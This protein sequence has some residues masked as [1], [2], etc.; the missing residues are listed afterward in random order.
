MSHTY[1]YSI[2]VYTLYNSSITF[3][4]A[5]TNNDRFAD[6]ELFILLVSFLLI[7]IS[8]ISIEIKSIPWFLHAISSLGQ[9]R[10]IIG[11]L[12]SNATSLIKYLIKQ[13]D[14]IFINMFNN[15]SCSLNNKKHTSKGPCL[16][17]TIELFRICSLFRFFVSN[18]VEFILLS[19]SKLFI[20]CIVLFIERI[21]MLSFVVDNTIPIMFLEVFIRSS[22]FRL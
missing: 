12:N 7:V 16:I 11:L 15:T 3:Q 19:K 2:I 5:M 20:I 22:F 10:T 13:E 21:F 14:I 8:L 6:L 18:N 1:L 9:D 17:L 4:G